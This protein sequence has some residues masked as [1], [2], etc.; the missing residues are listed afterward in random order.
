MLSSFFAAIIRHVVCDISGDLAPAGLTRGKE[1]E[2][3]KK[4][5]KEKSNRKRG[6]QLAGVS[7]PPHLAKK[8][9][10]VILLFDCQFFPP[11]PVSPYVPTARNRT[12]I[13]RKQQQQ[14]PISSKL[15]RMQPCILASWTGCT[16]SL[17]QFSLTIILGFCQG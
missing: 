7:S 2:K 10:Q 9:K 8:K 1:E 11:F 4:K 15:E 6:M 3:K 17:D 16:N 14:G 13:S 5:K 12:F